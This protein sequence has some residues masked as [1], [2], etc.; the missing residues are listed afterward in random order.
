[1]VFCIRCIGDSEVRVTAEDEQEA[2]AGKKGMKSTDDERM[3]TLITQK[4]PS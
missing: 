1:V 3:R 4:V 2:Q